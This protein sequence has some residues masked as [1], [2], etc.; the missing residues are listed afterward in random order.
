MVGLPPAD[1][2]MITMDNERSSLVFIFNQRGELALQL[3]SATIG[4]YPLH[5]D[6][7]AGGGVNP[8]E[9]P[10]TA[11]VREAKEE[12]G[13]VVDVTFLGNHIYRDALHQDHLFLYSARHEGPFALDPAE[14]RDAR[15]FTIDTVKYM[16]D[17]GVKFHP[18]FMFL[19]NLGIITNAAEGP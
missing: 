14:V 16:L 2:S 8:G 9:E 13:V 6:C 17:T 4:D 7:S 15:F 18:E 3:R 5:W 12:L 11:A 10:E 19:W 1:S